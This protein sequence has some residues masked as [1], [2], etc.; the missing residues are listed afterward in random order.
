MSTI[1]CAAVLVACGGDD[2][3]DP[4]IPE[5]RGPEIVAALERVR[6]RVEAGDCDGAEETAQSVRDAISALPAEVPDDLQQALVQ[7]SDNLIQ[8]IPDQCEPA[9][10][11]REPEPEPEPETGATGA[12]GAVP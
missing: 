5:E 12:E 2:E 10:K 1:A 4:S 11:D 7:G 6:E 3:P 8:R 9:E